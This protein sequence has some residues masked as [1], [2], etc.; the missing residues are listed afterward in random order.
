VGRK[1]NKRPFS[2][3]PPFIQ[4]FATSVIFFI[5]KLRGNPC[6]VMAFLQ[7]KNKAK[8]S[9]AETEDSMMLKLTYLFVK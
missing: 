8:W 2:F 6:M 4:R 7:D 9:L 1:K 3:F 5:A